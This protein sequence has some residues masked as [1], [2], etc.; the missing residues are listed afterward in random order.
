[1]R[2][3]ASF[4]ELVDAMFGR[5]PPRGDPLIEHVFR[6]STTPE[7]LDRALVT[8]ITVIKETP[9][10]ISACRIRQSQEMTI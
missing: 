1:M 9:R 4:D 2:V 3:D 8:P 5:R 6:M 7:D 10:T